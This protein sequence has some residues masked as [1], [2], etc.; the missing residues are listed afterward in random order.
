MKVALEHLCTSSDPAEMC[1]DSALTSVTGTRCA[2][3]ERSAGAD[4]WGAGDEGVRKAND[5]EA[6]ELGPRSLR[7]RAKG[8]WGAHVLPRDLARAA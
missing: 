8:G 4:R 3:T 7:Q 1:D 5:Q 6:E 2:G